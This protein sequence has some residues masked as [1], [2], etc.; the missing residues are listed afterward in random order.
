MIFPIT[1]FTFPEELQHD[2]LH[3][4]IACGQALRTV[5]AVIADVQMVVLVG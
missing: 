2:L 3:F 1:N 4:R 5:F